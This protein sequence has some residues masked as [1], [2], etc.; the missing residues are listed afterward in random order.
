[1]RQVVALSAQHVLE[2]FHVCNK[3]DSLAFSGGIKV[4]IFLSFIFTFL[5]I[6]FFFLFPPNR[7]L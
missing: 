3:M 5:P 6:F 4:I 2:R 1:M 7:D